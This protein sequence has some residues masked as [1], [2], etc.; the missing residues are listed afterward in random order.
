MIAT[1]LE[2]GTRDLGASI[3]LSFGVGLELDLPFD[4]DFSV[5]FGSWRFEGRTRGLPPLLKD[6]WTRVRDALSRLAGDR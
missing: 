5:A 3:G 2:V 1:G 4:G 6:V